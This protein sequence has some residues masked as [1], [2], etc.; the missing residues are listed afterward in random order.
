MGGRAAVPPS[1]PYDAARSTDRSLR[2]VFQ[3]IAH[4]KEAFPNR[5][6]TIDGRL[7]LEDLGWA[8]RTPAA[9]WDGLA[10]VYP[11]LWD[12]AGRPRPELHAPWLEVFA[13]VG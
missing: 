5:A 7:S 9:G 10:S 11:R 13:A 3:G 12:R 8:L 4:L 6:F 2:L 1:G